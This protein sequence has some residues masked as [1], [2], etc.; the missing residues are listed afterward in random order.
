MPQHG[1]ANRRRKEERAI[2]ELRYARWCKSPFG[3]QRAPKGSKGLGKAYERR[4]GKA[5]EE[6]YPSAIRHGPWI[7]FADAK[8]VGYCQPDYV[9]EIDAAFVIECKL[10]FVWEAHTK[11]RELYV[12]LLSALLGRPI[13]PII[14]VKH[15]TFETP[16]ARIVTTLDEAMG[17]ALEA[18]PILHWLG[19]GPI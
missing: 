14:I 17:V 11:L 1:E 19:R 13:W 18:P 9:V 2:D 10:T 15:V 16:K 8:G 12:P 6:R 5:L 3:K 4:V 7:T